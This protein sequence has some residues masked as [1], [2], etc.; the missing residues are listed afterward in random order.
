MNLISPVSGGN[1]KP[2]YYLLGCYLRY[3]INYEM[4][5]DQKEGQ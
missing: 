4:Q 2:N 5:H 3:R 1:K